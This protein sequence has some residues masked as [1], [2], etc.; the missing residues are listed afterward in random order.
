MGLL[1]CRGLPDTHIPACPKIPSFPVPPVNLELAVGQGLELDARYEEKHKEEHN[2]QGQQRARWGM[3]QVLCGQ[4]LNSQGMLGGG[5]QALIHS[6]YLSGEFLK[7]NHTNTERILA[8]I[9]TTE[10]ERKERLILRQTPG[11][12]LLACFGVSTGCPENRGCQVSR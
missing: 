12:W 2:A 1:P 7:R 6:F 5:I 11:T 3:L 9:S 8:V 10:R 4:S